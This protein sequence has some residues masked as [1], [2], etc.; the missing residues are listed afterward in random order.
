MDVF[1]LNGHFLK[2][3][4]SNGSLNSPWGETL[5]PDGFG[6]FG[7]DLLIGNFG[8]GQI[9]VFD[10][11]PGSFLATLGDGDGSPI[12]ID[13]LWGLT[14]EGDNSDVLH[15]T[16]GIAGGGQTEDHGLFGSLSPTPEPGTLCLIGT[17]ILGLLG[18]V[19]RRQ[20]AECS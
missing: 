6:P 20:R 16:A 14:F 12:S 7:G 11:T 10:P 18:V 2:R 4:V 15:V 3:L 9:N 13:G 5:A 1:D 8:N 19:R 17:G